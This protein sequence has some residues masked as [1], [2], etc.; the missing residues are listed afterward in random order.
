MAPALQQQLSN[1]GFQSLAL[2]AAG[3]FVYILTKVLK[4]RY[5]GWNFPNPGQAALP[6][7][8]LVIAWMILQILFVLVFIRSGAQ[9]PEE[10]PE[11]QY[12]FSRFLNQAMV[13]LILVGPAL[14]LMRLRKEPLASAGV[15][16]YN[17]GGA[18]LVGLILAAASFISSNG[19]QA[20]A[21]GLSRNQLWALPYFAAVGFGEE[22]LFRGYLQIRLVAWLGQLPGWLL[23]SIVMAMMHIGQRVAVQGLSS[24]E[25][26]LSSALL[27]PISLFMGFV[28]LRTGNI[29]APGIAHT[30]ANWVGALG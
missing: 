19:M 7:L 8:G 16:R 1:L 28:M 27:I 15:S 22:F 23:T 18:L 24:P 9:P 21:Q 11:V 13:Y 14:V 3:V 30:F 10:S 12:N 4:L 5:H 6:A 29:I 2:F 17:L 20:L 25:A 26:L